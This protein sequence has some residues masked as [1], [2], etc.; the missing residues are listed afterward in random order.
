MRGISNLRK[1]VKIL[2]AEPEAPVLLPFETAII[3]IGTGR[4]ARGYLEA[5]IGST[6]ALSSLRRRHTL[7]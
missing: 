1:K 5:L 7:R 3:L 4:T 6:D 2:P